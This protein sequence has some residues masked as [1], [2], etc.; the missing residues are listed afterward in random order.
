MVHPEETIKK[1]KLQ[2]V[3]KR[4]TNFYNIIVQNYRRIA[5]NLPDAY[6]CSRNIH[7]YIDIH[8]YITYINTYIHIYIYIY[9]E[10][11]REREREFPLED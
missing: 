1:K 2:R 7:K 5:K 10:R 3:P 6:M 9:I 4:T 8:K 11:E